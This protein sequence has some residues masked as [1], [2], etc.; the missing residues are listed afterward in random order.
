MTFG[1]GH[2][3]LHQTQGITG[4]FYRQRKNECDNRPRKNLSSDFFQRSSDSVSALLT[5]IVINENCIFLFLRDREN[6]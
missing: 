6:G 4:T 3:P 2:S 5:L 1:D